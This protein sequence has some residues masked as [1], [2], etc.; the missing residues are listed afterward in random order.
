LRSFR[1]GDLRH[2]R[3]ADLIVQQHSTGATYYAEEG[4]DGFLQWGNVT[5]SLGPHW[6]TV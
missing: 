6:Q 4:T 3:H 2:N 1:L 5:S